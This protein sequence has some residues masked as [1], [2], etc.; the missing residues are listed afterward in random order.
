M[1]TKA[2]TLSADRPALEIRSG[3]EVVR[4]E[5]DILPCKLECERLEKRH[6][7]EDGKPTLG[8]A[9]EFRS[10]LQ[11]QGM[12]QC[13]IDLAVKFY[14]LIRYQFAKLSQSLLDQLEG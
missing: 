3:G 1:T 10:Y 12:P 14:H 11:S 7:V 6:G 5:Y 4:W 13:S 8:L 2:I 9:E